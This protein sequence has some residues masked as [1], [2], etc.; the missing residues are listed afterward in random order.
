[1]KINQYSI[2]KDGIDQLNISDRSEDLTIIL[3]STNSLSDR[4]THHELS[5]KINSKNIIFCSTSGHFYD[6]LVHDDTFLVNGITFD[7]TKVDCNS[8]TYSENQ[9][10][11][12]IGADILK[13]M[14]NNDLTH[15]MIFAD[16]HFVNSDLLIQ[17]LQTDQYTFSI[18]GAIAGDGV[19]F[20]ET[21]I[22]LN[23]LPSTN[24]IVA[25]GFY[26]QN[27]KVKTNKCSGFHVF[28]PQRTVTKSNLNVLEELDGK[29][30]LDLYKE[31]LGHLSSELP[32]SAL[33]FPL[34]ILDKEG[35]S[36]IRT[37]LSID[38][39]SK[40]MTFAGNI[41]QGSVVNLMR[42]NIDDLIDNVEEL[43]EEQIAFPV[44][45][46][47]IASC[48]GRRIIMESRVE[49]EI[50]PF[51]EIYKN[52]PMTGLYSYGEICSSEESPVLHN[53]TMVITYFS[54]K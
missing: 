47:F 3:S 39:K 12:E 53:Q 27:L 52:V 48:V 6:E 26:G 20:S 34:S 54:E 21:L 7:K 32:G 18:S 17:G 42:T 37:V 23:D 29:P 10:E 15:L 30:A 11:L 8:W 1:M 9:D 35:N 25:I 43:S 51:M 24:Q 50:L 19:R 38:E 36:T 44:E 5:Q 13:T 46:I 33:Y 31:Y 28:G 4:S 16:G 49:E 40:T 41:P 22:G 2:T 14:V 45:Y